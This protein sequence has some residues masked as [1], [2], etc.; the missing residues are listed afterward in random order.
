MDNLIEKNISNLVEHQFPEFFR[1]DGPTFVLFVKKYYEWLE[2]KSYEAVPIDKGTVSFSAKN[3]NITGLNTYFLTQFQV[4][5]Y[6]ALYYD[7]TDGFYEYFTVTEIISDTKLKIDAA[8]LT[9][10]SNK[11]MFGTVNLD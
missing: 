2:G 6:I 8:N 5:D 4:G 10:S 11:S 3:E 9:Y 7:D 1:T